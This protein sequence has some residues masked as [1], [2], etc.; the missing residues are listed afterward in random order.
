MT[1]TTIQVRPKDATKKLNAL[2]AEGWKVVG[3]SES[4]WVIRKCCGLSNTV[5]S[6]LN[7]TLV[8]E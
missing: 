2:G 1:Y 5:D 8:K 6:I 7:I 3:Q 4:T